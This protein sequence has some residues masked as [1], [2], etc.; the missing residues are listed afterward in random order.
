M[1]KLISNRVL[2][3]ELRVAINHIDDHNFGYAREIISQVLDR[4]KEYDLVVQKSFIKK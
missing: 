3:T 4:V 2:Q 1:K